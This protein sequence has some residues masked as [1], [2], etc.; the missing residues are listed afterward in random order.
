MP[1]KGKEKKRRAPG[2]WIPSNT[3]EGRILRR[4]RRSR[5]SPI[6]VV[7]LPTQVRTSLT[8][9]STDRSIDRPWDETWLGENRTVAPTALSETQPYGK[10]FAFGSKRTLHRRTI[11]RRSKLRANTEGSSKA[12]PTF[13]VHV[14]F[15]TR[16]FHSYK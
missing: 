4:N 11:H 13:E 1:T 9:Q 8:D 7:D 2:W 14:G 3:I 15:V 10:R 5:L 16:T 12:R 6:Y